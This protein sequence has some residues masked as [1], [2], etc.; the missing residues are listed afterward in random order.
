M[1]KRFNSKDCL[2]GT[3]SYD[4]ELTQLIQTPM[5]QRLRHIRLSNI[6]SVSMPSI[7]NISRYEHVLGVGYLTTQTQLFRRLS[8]FDRLAFTGAALLHDWAITAFGHLVEE[9]FRYTKYEFDHERKL[10][11]L[12]VSKQAPEIGGADLQILFGRQAQLRQWAEK[13][14]GTAKADELLHTIMSHIEGSSKL[15]RFIS[16][17]MDLD[18]ID[19]VFRM[20]FHMGLTEARNC[21][22]LLAQSMVDIHNAT[23]VPIFATT[24][25]EELARW[26]LTRHMVYEHL[27]L[28]S[29]DFVGKLMLLYATVRAIE[30]DEIRAEDWHLTDEKLLRR[31]TISKHKQVKETAIRWIVGEPWQR[32]PL[33]WMRGSRPDFPELREFSRVISEVLS[34]NIFVYG[35]KDKRYRKVDVYFDDGTTVSLGQV[36]D[37]WL[38][39]AGA[40]ERRSIKPAEVQIL[41]TS[42]EEAFKSEVVSIASNPLDMDQKGTAPGCLL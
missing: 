42:A 2:Y 16:G 22:V 1:M 25:Q 38:F 19:G 3:I 9:A 26:V 34:R 37:Q 40:S 14:V 32:T 24:A 13:T 29:D 21:P 35:I 4:S 31:L 33:Y 23:G 28:A 17:D 39:G 41:L 20:A 7:A 27:M 10:T 8:Q 12:L 6:D 36:S 18:N 30:E 5:I 11:E 15:G